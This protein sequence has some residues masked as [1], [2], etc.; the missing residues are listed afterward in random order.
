MKGIIIG[1]VIGFVVATVG[2]TG[3]INMLGTGVDKL[4]EYAPVVESTVNDVKRQVTDV[5]R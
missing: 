3:A 1:V 5:V 4:K 2:V